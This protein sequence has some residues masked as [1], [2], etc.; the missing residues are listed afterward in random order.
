MLLLLFAGVGIGDGV[1]GVESSKN[2]NQT[3]LPPLK[4]HQSNYNL[5][6]L[7]VY[8]NEHNLNNNNNSLKLVLNLGLRMNK[9]YPC[10]LWYLFQF[11]KVIKTLNKYVTRVTKCKLISKSRWRNTNHYDNKK[12]NLFKYYI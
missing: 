1:N 10:A 11:W 7:T 9:H 3:V 12:H 2:D 4:Y 5:Y 6:L 8:C